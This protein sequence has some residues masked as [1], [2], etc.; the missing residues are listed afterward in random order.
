VIDKTIRPILEVVFYSLGLSSLA[1]LNVWL[2]K[3]V[4]AWG[5]S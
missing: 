3:L 2:W 5:C 4:L 1:A